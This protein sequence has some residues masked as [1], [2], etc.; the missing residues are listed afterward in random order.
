MTF[1]KMSLY[2]I[3]CLP[4]TEIFSKRRK[5]YSWCV[6]NLRCCCRMSARDQTGSSVL[7]GLSFHAFWQFLPKTLHL[8]RTPQVFQCLSCQMTQTVAAISFIW[9][10][11]GSL[12]GLT[13]KRLRSCHLAVGCQI[14][15]L[16][17]QLPGVYLKRRSLQLSQHAVMPLASRDP[18]QDACGKASRRVK[19]PPLLRYAP[20][21]YM[22][23]GF[24]VPSI[25]DF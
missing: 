24:L 2:S 11:Y 21:D 13:C 6:E 25:V 5:I 19:Q 15:V 18:R 8:T 7:M 9:A 12:K 1:R 14:R 22:S 20:S 17:S 23:L 10:F 4:H 3:L 16:P